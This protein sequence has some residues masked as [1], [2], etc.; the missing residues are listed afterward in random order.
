MKD[1]FEAWARRQPASAGVY[2]R[3]K[4][5]PIA[6]VVNGEWF[7]PVAWSA[8]QAGA[9]SR[10]GAL[11]DA[12]IKLLAAAPRSLDCHNFHHDKSDQHHMLDQC[13]PHT[14]Y[15]NA[16]ALADAAIAATKE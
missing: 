12:L 1:A 11:R 7:S 3:V 6:G 5:E 10:D 15:V 2:E 14:R 8:Y 13:M 4:G 16:L 9:A